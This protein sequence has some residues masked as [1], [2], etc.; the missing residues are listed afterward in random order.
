M[1][2]RVQ[3]EKI[4]KG[5]PEYGKILY[6]ETHKLP[7]GV[8]NS[9]VDIQMKLRECAPNFWEKFFQTQE[10]DQ[11][12]SLSLNKQ[13]GLPLTIVWNIAQEELAKRL[14]WSDRTI[15]RK[16]RA[17]RLI[18][19]QGWGAVPIGK[20][21]A[22]YCGVTLN[23]MSYGD[24]KA[25]VALLKQL[26][27]YERGYKRLSSDP[28]PLKS[29]VRRQAPPKKSKKFVDLHI[30]PDCLSRED[31]HQI[32]NEMIDLIERKKEKC[33]LALLLCLTMGLP[34]KEI[35]HVQM[36]AILC[37]K[38]HMPLAIHILGA[39][40]KK[41]KRIETEEY[42][43]NSPKNRVLPIP[44]KVALVMKDLLDEWRKQDSEEVYQERYLIPN[45]KNKHRRTD[46]KE[47]EA[48]INTHLR[49]RLRDERM[50]DGTGKVIGTR[51]PYHRC[52]STF[53]LSLPHVGFESDE[54]RYYLGLTPNTT[55]GEY[56]CDF[57][58][59]AEQARMRGLIDQW[60]GNVMP[61][62]LYSS[63]SSKNPPAKHEVTFGTTGQVAHVVLEIDVPPVPEK[64]IP[65]EGYKLQFWAKQGFSLDARST[66]HRNSK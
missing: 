10:S 45:D 20:L 8:K 46:S 34:L 16:A 9:S 48:W 28:W 47:I 66:K 33:A 4:V 5:E 13:E 23:G 2:F 49:G 61:V 30:R 64:C 62:N 26:S 3:K 35:C 65:K 57:R 11:F 15:R 17:M 6:E 38:K 12:V 27:E 58:N 56:Y 40:K 31:V 53:R 54:L 1:S 41:K 42:T 18:R 19:A 44:T 50:H 63:L 14:S 24:H 29:V 22:L 32:V 21:D 43:E 7:N 52:L 55:A 59:S 51:S 36:K 60:L 25:V 37:N 39:T